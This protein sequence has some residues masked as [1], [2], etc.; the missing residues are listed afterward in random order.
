MLNAHKNQTDDHHLDSIG[1]GAVHLTG[2]RCVPGIDRWGAW[3]WQSSYGGAADEY[4]TADIHQY[5][6]TDRHADANKYAYANQHADADKYAYS[7]GYTDADKYAQANK[8]AP[9]A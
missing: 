4:A 3:W 7:H 5:T 1:H 6:H 8:A 2:L 9:A